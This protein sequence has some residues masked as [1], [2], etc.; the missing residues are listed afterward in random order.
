MT[1]DPPSERPRVRRVAGARRAVLPAVEG[2]DVSP[3]S[4]VPTRADE[5]TEIAWGDRPA[6]TGN[7]EQL[8]RDVPPHWG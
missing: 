5:D 4:A 3:Q 6:T 2:T 8:R 1:D 7:E